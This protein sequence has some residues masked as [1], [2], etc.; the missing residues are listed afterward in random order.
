MNPRLGGREP[1]IEWEPMADSTSYESIHR[2]EPLPPPCLGRKT[3][4][5][6]RPE[7]PWGLPLTE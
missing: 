3:P 4:N 2:I 6:G 7:G 5:D 1:G